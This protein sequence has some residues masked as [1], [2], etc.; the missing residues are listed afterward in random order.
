M[1]VVKGTDEDPATCSTVWCWGA[2]SSLINSVVETSTI[3]LASC[4]Y[5]RVDESQLTTRVL[6]LKS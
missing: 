1:R 6:K 3:N 4:C 2:H 5:L